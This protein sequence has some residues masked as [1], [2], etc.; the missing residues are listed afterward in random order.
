[1]SQLP[2]IPSPTSVEQPARESRTFADAYAAQI[3]INPQVEQLKENGYI[4][5]KTVVVLRPYDYDNDV[6]GPAEQ[7]VRI[8]IDDSRVLGGILTKR[9]NDSLQ[10]ALASVV[11]AL[12]DLPNVAEIA[13][14]MSPGAVIDV[15]TD[16][17]QGTIEAT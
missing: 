2:R 5:F 1:M 9:G 13:E 12:A 10:T 4:P 3:A 8:E 11:N 16:R 14:K 6:M 7:G 17:D 15:K